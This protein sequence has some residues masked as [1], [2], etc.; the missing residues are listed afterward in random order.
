MLKRCNEVSK[1]NNKIYVNGIPRIC[2]VKKTKNKNRV[3][4]A[5]LNSTIMFIYGLRTK[6]TEFRVQLASCND[7]L[8]PPTNVWSD[9]SYSE[10]GR[11]LHNI[12]T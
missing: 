6:L 11:D 5:T 8:L 12:F 2:T 3:K 4:A 9:M 1:P 10:I 7:H